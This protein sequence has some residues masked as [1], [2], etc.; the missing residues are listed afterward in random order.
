MIGERAEAYVRS[1][2]SLVVFTA[3]GEVDQDARLALN[4]QPYELI[5]SFF[6]APANP[7]S[8]PR[9]YSDR[10]QLWHAAEIMGATRRAEPPTEER[11][12]LITV[13]NFPSFYRHYIPGTLTYKAS[14]VLAR[15]SSSIVIVEDP[16]P[17]DLESSLV[18]EQ[19]SVQVVKDLVRTTEVHVLPEP[20]LAWCALMG[21]EDQQVEIAAVWPGDLKRVRGLYDDYIRSS[22]GFA[23]A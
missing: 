9:R 11:Q 20:A 10:D 8:L 7:E 12:Q 4:D 1:D 3:P 2:E 22:T 13:G 21:K 5:R 19:M 18:Y 23:D 6:V 14:P 15:V 17:E 16:L